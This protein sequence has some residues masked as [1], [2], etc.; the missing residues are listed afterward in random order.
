[1]AGRGG[2]H[3]L[4]E[5]LVHKCGR[6]FDQANTYAIHAKH[7]DGTKIPTEGRIAARQKETALVPVRGRPRRPAAD[8]KVERRREQ[9]RASK[10]RRRGDG[11]DPGAAL[12][13]IQAAATD[14]AMEIVIAGL[15]ARRDAID[16]ALEALRVVA[17]R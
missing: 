5:P 10:Q 14:K 6:S 1:M 16:R 11:V 7:C 3:K 17:V 12:P 2:T 8:P 13:A 9:Y 4:S 15:L